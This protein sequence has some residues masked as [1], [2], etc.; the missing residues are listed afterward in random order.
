MAVTPLSHASSS[1]S[2]S[3]TTTT[4][5]TTASRRATPRLEQTVDPSRELV[6]HVNTAD[7]TDAVRRIVSTV[8]RPARG[9][10]LAGRARRRMR[11]WT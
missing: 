9:A 1:S 5:T 6:V 2:S 7:A 4:T 3:S 11:P 8:C 10:P